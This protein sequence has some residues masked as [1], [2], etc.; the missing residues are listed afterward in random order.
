M[1]VREWRREWKVAGIQLIRFRMNWFKISIIIISTSVFEAIL[2]NIKL[3]V[4][5]Q[6]FF[7]RQNCYDM[8]VIITD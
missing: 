1:G 5:I 6:K 2:H 7:V 8:M 3:L 4:F